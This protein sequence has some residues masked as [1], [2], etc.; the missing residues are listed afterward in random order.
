MDN[1]RV[2]IKWD[3]LEIIIDTG[4]YLYPIDLEKCK[5]SAGLLD[6]IYQV[7]GKPWCDPE[8]MKE[9][10]DTFDEACRVKF[11]QPVQGCFCSFGKDHIVDWKNVKISNKPSIS[12]NNL[13]G[14][15]API[16]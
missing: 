12:N 5:N 14:F 13:Q 11:N 10:L 4:K 7:S 9:L 3:T 8:L 6:Y 16:R 15:G 1:K 2:T